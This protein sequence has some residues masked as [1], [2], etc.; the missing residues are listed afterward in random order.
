MW[1][2]LPVRYMFSPDNLRWSMGS[3]DICFK[4]R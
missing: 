3:H 2:V 4:N 1:G